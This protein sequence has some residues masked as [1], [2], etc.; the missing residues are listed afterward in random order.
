MAAR[1]YVRL[2]LAGVSSVPDISVVQTLLRQASTAVRR[3]T[4][5]AW[6]ADGLALMASALR[7]LLTEAEPG[8]DEQLAYLRAFTGVAVSAHDLA[9]IAGLLDG[10]VDLEG[11]SVDTD[12]RWTL[13]SR[14]VSRGVRSAAAIDAEVARDATDAGERYAATCHA[15][16]PTAAAKQVAWEL[17]T[18]GKLPLATFRAVLGG[19]VDLDQ[20]ELIE[21]YESAYFAAVGSVWKDWS[22]AMAQDFVSGLYLVCPVATSTVSATDAYIAAAEPLAALRRLLNEGRDD[23]LRALRCQERDRQEA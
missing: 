12:L 19:F 16:I 14:L 1:D 17:L 8:S 3:F 23:T 9:L 18:G 4:D 21:P 22:S 2:V 7:T 15:A 11:L 10:S 20:P 6:R 13:L 5:P